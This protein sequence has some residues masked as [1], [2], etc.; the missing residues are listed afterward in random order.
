MSTIRSLQR[1]PRLSYANVTSTLA[2]VLA[3][4]GGSAYAAS[5]L[6]R[7]SQIAPGSISARQ[8]KTGS[9]LGADFKPGQLPA[10]PQGPAGGQGPQGPQGAPGTAVAWGAVTTNAAGNPFFITQSGFPGT[11]TEPSPGIFCVAP[12]AGY[13]QVPLILSAAG[14][15]DTVPQEISNQQ[16]GGTQYEISASM[17]LDHGAAFNIAVP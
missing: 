9:L 13:L 1:K 10:G 4:G 8:I 15:T 6:I 14:N 12:P 16:C 11:V 3:L 7:G 5:H 2:L 17:S